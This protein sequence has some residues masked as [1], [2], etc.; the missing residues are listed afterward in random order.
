MTAAGFHITNQAFLLQIGFL[1]DAQVLHANIQ[2]ER[3]GGLVGLPSLQKAH[4]FG[5]LCVHLLRVTIYEL[6]CETCY[7]SL[8]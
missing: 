8:V 5:K 3:A 1:F 2:P 7:L 4:E 6:Q